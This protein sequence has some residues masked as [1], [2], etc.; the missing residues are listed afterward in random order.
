MNFFF[1]KN[2][3]EAGHVFWE[4]YDYEYKSVAYMLDREFTK[5]GRHPQLLKD[6]SPVLRT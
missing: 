4:D 6:P 3:L 2:T 5:H 1:S